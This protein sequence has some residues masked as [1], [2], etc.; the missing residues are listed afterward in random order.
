MK[1]EKL[2]IE[3][4]AKGIINLNSITFP[5]NVA[6]IVKEL[7]VDISGVTLAGSCT[8]SA[9]SIFDTA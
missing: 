7:I 3:K 5:G 6:S 2:V 9:H 4:L 8:S 1:F